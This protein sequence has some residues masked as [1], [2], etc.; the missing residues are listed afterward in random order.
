M[1]EDEELEALRQKK[2][3]ELQ[4][5]Q[6]SAQMQ[7]EQKAAHEAQKQAI[8]RQILTEEAKQRLTNVKLVRPQLAE[9]VEVRLIQLAQQGA[10]SDKLSDSQLKDILRKIQGQKRETK[11]DIRRL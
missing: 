3:A 4:E 9:A 8:L 6:A 2:L 5:Q 7:E 11:I 10:I 1:Y